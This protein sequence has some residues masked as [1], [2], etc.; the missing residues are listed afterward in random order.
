M[1]P[2]ED[3]TKL[4]DRE[5]GAV[6]NGREIDRAARDRVALRPDRCV[7]LRIGRLRNRAENGAQESN[8]RK[9]AERPATKVEKPFHDDPTPGQG[10]NVQS[11]TPESGPEEL[12]IRQSSWLATAA[13]PVV[14]S[15]RQHETEDRPSSG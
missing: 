14:A 13:F 12:V 3:G 11:I 5:A 15:R 9:A 7:E 8:G 6:R 10:P 2:V 1:P 4:C